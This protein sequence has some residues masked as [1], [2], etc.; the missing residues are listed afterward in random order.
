M[1]LPIESCKLCG[2]EN[3]EK[4]S[5]K[6]EPANKTIFV[7]PIVLDPYQVE[8]I[9]EYGDVIFESFCMNGYVEVCSVYFNMIIQS[10]KYKNMVAS[11]GYLKKVF[12]GKQFE[13][14]VIENV[15]GIKI[16]P[17][18]GNYLDRRV[19]EEIK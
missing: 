10:R 19:K 9:S 4:Q 8:I 18:T 2:L 16:I 6:F 15:N 17:V 11:I 12:Q 5:P 13:E 3:F 14:Y 7:L 1:Q